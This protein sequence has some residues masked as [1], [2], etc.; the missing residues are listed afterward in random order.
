MEEQ[1]GCRLF[2]R[3][4]RAVWLTD[5]GEKLLPAV[6]RALTE[7]EV[8]TRQIG[9]L[10]SQSRS[11]LSVA[12]TPLVSADVLPPLFRQLEAAH[13]G[14]S[15]VLHDVERGQLLPLVESGQVDVVLGVL[16]KPATGVTREILLSVPLVCLSPA[17]AA[18]VGPLSWAALR[19]LPLISLPGDNVMQQH[20]DALL[21]A[22]G[23][24]MEPRRVV[25]QL[26]TLMAM[27]ETGFGH[28]VVPAFVCGA[29]ARYRLRVRRIANHEPLEFYAV[30]RSGRERPPLLEEFL[31]M[32]VAEM[33]A[34]QL[35][36]HDSRG[37][38]PR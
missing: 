31:G 18:A 35:R 5:A 15:L 10:A 25:K 12:A 4:T 2:N 3:T 9:E 33:R 17:V 22:N 8:A 20:I 36:A 29:A 37:S 7:I 24:D 28:A 21:T 26:G 38:P 14:I 27:V 30:T 11:R 32:F 13:P 16:I 6:E 19:K 34:Q 23:R 1:V